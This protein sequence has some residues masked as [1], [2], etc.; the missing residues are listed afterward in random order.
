[1]RNA[2][3]VAAGASSSFASPTLDCVRPAL[4]G[5]GLPTRPATLYLPLGNGNLV[6]V[7][8]DSHR[9]EPTAD[10]PKY[11]RDAYNSANANSLGEL[12]NPGCQ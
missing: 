12:L 8:V 5:A 1:M 9:L 10:W 2:A 6:S 3:A 7:V 11:Q 4:G